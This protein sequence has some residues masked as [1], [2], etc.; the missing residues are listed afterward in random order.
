MKNIAE[1][2]RRKLP[3]HRLKVNETKV[4]IPEIETG[5]SSPLRHLQG[6]PFGTRHEGFT[7]SIR[8]RKSPKPK[9]LP[10]K[11]LLVLEWAIPVQL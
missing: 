6:S 10:L 11:G 2:T 1:K 7:N 8:F 4:D 5:K 3:K 9:S